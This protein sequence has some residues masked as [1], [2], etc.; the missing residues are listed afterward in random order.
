MSPSWPGGTR[1]PAAARSAAARGGGDQRAVPALEPDPRGPGKLHARD[2]MNYE[3]LGGSWLTSECGSVAHGNVDDFSRFMLL[4]QAAFSG[5]DLAAHVLALVPPPLRRDCGP[6]VRRLLPVRH[7]H[8]L[9][10]PSGQVR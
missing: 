7:Q 8:R 6:D 9:G 2:V 10:S 4:E 3:R 5:A 1:S